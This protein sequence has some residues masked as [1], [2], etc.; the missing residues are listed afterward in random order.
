MIEDQRFKTLRH[1]ETVRNYLNTII[2]QLLARA[3]LH[4]QTKLQDPERPYFDK[5]TPLLRDLKYGSEE[6]RNCLKEMMPAIEHHNKHNRHHPEFFKNGI[7]DMNLIDLIEMLCD[8]KA[9]GLRHTTGDLIK[10]IEINEMRFGLSFQLVCIL[11]NTAKLLN[12]SQ[13]YHH[14]DES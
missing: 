4:D 7:E 14:A 1:I 6:Y 13:T 9:A 10:S 11:K 8:W 5:Y 2:H 3:E 12:D